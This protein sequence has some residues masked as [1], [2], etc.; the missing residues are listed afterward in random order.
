MEAAISIVN[1]KEI[2][3]SGELTDELLSQLKDI[4]FESSAIKKFSDETGKDNFFKRWCGDYL[5]HWPGYCWLAIKD[6]RLLGYLVGC[7]DSH[8]GAKVLTMPGYTI[9]SEYFD[10]FPGHLHMNVHHST[11]G[12]GVGKYLL[13]RFCLQAKEQNIPG[14]FIITAA[15]SRPT[16]FYMKNNFNYSYTKEYGSSALILMGRKL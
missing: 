5:T 6:T 11:R 2:T 13:D 1:L 14:I 16:H 15:M 7:P 9:F 12:E 3:N 4:F 10:E 8:E